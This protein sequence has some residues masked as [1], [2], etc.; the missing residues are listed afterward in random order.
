MLRLDNL[1]ALNER[2]FR[3]SIRHHLSGKR[4]KL[5]GEFRLDSEK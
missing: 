5:N 1:I 4:L 2:D 3:V